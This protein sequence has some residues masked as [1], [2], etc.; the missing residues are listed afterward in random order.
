MDSNK[1]DVRQNAGR[2]DICGKL[3]E[4]DGGDVLSISEPFGVSDDVSEEHGVSD[5]DAA[6]AVA[7]ALERCDDS[8]ETYELAK[9]IRTDLEFRVHER[10]LE[11]TAYDQLTE[12]SE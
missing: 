8:P 12:P 2:C 3:V 11:K 7:D 4:M 6:D 10:C 1:P 9:T 5:Q